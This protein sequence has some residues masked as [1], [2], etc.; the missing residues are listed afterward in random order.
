VEFIDA[1]PKSGI[2]KILRR[3][4]RNRPLHGGLGPRPPLDATEQ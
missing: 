3:D 4:L 2:G 1:L